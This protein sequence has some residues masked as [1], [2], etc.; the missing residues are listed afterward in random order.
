MTQTDRLKKLISLLSDE[1]KWNAGMNPPETES[2]LFQIYRSLV[3]IRP[4]QKAPE[5]FLAIQ[6]A[7]LQEN[8][9]QRGTVSFEDMDGF[10]G[11]IFLWRGD[12]TQIQCDAIVNAANSQM[13]GCFSPCH[14]CIDNCIHT[15]AGIELR[16]ECFRVIQE[17][18]HEE[19]TGDAQITRGY[20]LPA[21]FVIHTTGPI[22]NGLLR[23][24]HK[25]ALAACYRNSL[26]VAEEN[27]LKSVAF[28]CISTGV[29]G[30]PKQEACQIAFRTIRQFKPADMKVAFNVFS[31][32]DEA[33]YREMLEKNDASH[34]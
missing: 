8:L 2:G 4:P 19:E 28:C 13:L 3:N 26:K 23:P 12:I 31:K 5:G 6:D 20:N 21:K 25:A 14:A 9:K 22:C 29:F 1:F 16:N 17:L 15:F 34:F 24:Q 27:G 30:F 18:G 11:Q 32:E 7:Y 10:P 33:L